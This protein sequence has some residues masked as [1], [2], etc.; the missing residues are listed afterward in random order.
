MAKTKP[1]FYD[2]R[3]VLWTPHAQRSVYSS[4]SRQSFVVGS[5]NSLTK[6]RAVS[7]SLSGFGGSSNVSRSTLVVSVPDRRS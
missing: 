1:K 2:Q 4:R 5:L 6:Q 3:T 7:S